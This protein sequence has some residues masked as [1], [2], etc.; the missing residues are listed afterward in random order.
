MFVTQIVAE[1]GS[2][3]MLANG[4]LIPARDSGSLNRY[5]DSLN[6]HMRSII[7]DLG[8][9]GVE[10]RIIGDAVYIDEIGV[11]RHRGCAMSLQCCSCQ[12]EKSLQN[13][14][15]VSQKENWTRQDVNNAWMRNSLSW[16]L[17]RL[18]LGQR[19]NLGFILNCYISRF[20]LIDLD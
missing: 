5:A 11:D 16:R 12:R 18:Y 3:D 7:L 4:V 8:L 6:I 1:V 17:A 15:F 10:E 9:T 14:F 19:F 20:N 2:I 13:E